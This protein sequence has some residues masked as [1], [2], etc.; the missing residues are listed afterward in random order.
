MKFDGGVV[1]VHFSAFY[2]RPEHERPHHREAK[3]HLPFPRI[4][5]AYWSEILFQ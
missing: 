1:S 2:F 5:A 4:A 3:A